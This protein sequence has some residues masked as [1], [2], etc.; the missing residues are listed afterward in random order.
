MN[1]FKAPFILNNHIKEYLTGE[2]FSNY[3]KF[4]FENRTYIPNRIDLLESTLKDKVILHMG[5]CDHEDI[6][7]E[8]IKNNTHL[9]VNISK[10]A[11]K[12]MGV[13]INIEALNKLKSLN[14]D[15]CMY[16]NVYES[17][18]P[19]LE[20]E[21][22]DYIL[23]GEI[24]EHISDPVLFLKT[25]HEKFVNAKKIIITV[26]NAFSSRNI[27]NIKKGVEEIN[28]DHKFWFTPFTISKV[29]TEANF[30][31]ESIYFVDRSRISFADKIV[32]W[33][34]TLQNKNPFTS[35]KWNIIKANGLFV[36]AEF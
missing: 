31:L 35:R 13:D 2:K 27:Y 25:I 9:H 8:K 6:I 23:L 21:I 3:L 26:P 11:K 28:T 29:I 17:V 24:L 12:C 5:C 14:I 18:D 30:K 10:I 33:F 32:K 20:N 34:Y 22:Y 1:K 7:E 16:Y 19:I 4:K 36:I 15:N